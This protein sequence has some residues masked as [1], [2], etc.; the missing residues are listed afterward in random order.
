MQ[1]VEYQK[2]RGFLSTVRDIKALD[3]SI[4][5]AAVKGLVP[6]YIARKILES[7]IVGINGIEGTD[8]ISRNQIWPFVFL[9]GT[10]IAHPFYLIGLRTQAAPFE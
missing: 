2:G 5:R 9:A 8:V 3:G 4:P 7:T 1:N 10:L 6:F